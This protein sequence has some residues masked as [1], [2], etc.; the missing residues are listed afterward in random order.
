[1][2]KKILF[3][4]GLAICLGWMCRTSMAQEVVHALTG[5]VSS[6]DPVGKTITLFLDG[7]SE[8]V[9]KDMTHAKTPL[10]VDKKLL[11]DATMVDAFKQKGAYVIVFYFGGIDSRTAVALR[12]LGTGPFSASDGTV[13]RFEGREHAISVED[14]SGTV[15]TFKINADTVAEGYAG[16]VDGL[17]FQAQKDDH[18][19]VVG[20]SQNGSLI[21][22]FVSEK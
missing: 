7:G 1:M 4:L 12:S 18:V 6:I 10:S 17:K 13:T 2:F 21:A 15:Q 14:K 11:V 22:L 20:T 19:H 9:F 5:T 3:A 16:A 8:G